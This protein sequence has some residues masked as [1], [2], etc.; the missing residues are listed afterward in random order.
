MDD[1][2][3]SRERLEQR[4]D[5]I[6]AQLGNASNNERIELD[7]DPEEQAIQLEQQDVSVAIADGLRRELAD[8]EDK[9]AQLDG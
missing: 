4:R 8:V 6:N 3:E 2:K 1:I 9:L 7:V 5:E